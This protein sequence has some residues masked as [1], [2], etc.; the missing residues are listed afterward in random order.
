MAR[1]KDYW[2]LSSTNKTPS[3]ERWSWSWLYWG[4]F[5]CP[6]IAM[7]DCF[8]DL[9]I[10]QFVLV[11]TSVWWMMSSGGQDHEKYHFPRAP[12]WANSVSDWSMHP[13]HTSSLEDES[14]LMRYSECL[15]LER[16]YAYSAGFMFHGSVYQRILASITV[17]TSCAA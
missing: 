13:L 2:C 1:P 3:L 10:I 14:I 11:L 12:V 8:C 9:E 16:T 17:I 6:W 7:S 4:C 15:A 5:Y